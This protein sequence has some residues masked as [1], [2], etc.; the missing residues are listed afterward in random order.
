MD[1]TPT[2]KI[3]LDAQKELDLLMTSIEEASKH[4]RNLLLALLV[5]AVYVLITAYA[6]TVSDN[7]KLPVFDVEVHI[8]AFYA[9]SPIIVL[10]IY[11]YMHVYVGEVKRRLRMFDGVTVE[12]HFV[13]NAR[14]LL[15]PWL[16]TFYVY[17]TTP[18]AIGTPSEA[19]DDDAPR[20][21]VSWVSG[22]IINLLGPLVLFTLWINFVGREDPISIIPCLCFVITLFSVSASTSAGR[23]GNAL[24]TLFGV[25]ILVITLA[26][27]PSYRETLRLSELWAVTSYLWLKLKAL[28]PG[29]MLGAIAAFG[30]IYA[31]MSRLDSML[32]SDARNAVASHIE[33]QAASLP[34][35]RSFARKLLWF[36]D[37]KRK[38]LQVIGVFVGAI[39]AITLIVIRVIFLD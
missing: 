6:G 36:T 9:I 5:S 26:S 16:L 22:F 8:G 4:A 15:F 28:F 31:A 29:V 38:P 2:S 3:S 24:A 39:A 21:Y 11:L 7:L 14:T 10:G 34:I 23:T 35:G 20:L 17:R 12:C 27:V 32:T 18:K 30:S 1:S 33:N 13:S 25:A 37:Y 19:N